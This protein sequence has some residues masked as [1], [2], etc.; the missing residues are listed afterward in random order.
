MNYANQHPHVCSLLVVV[1]CFCA[2]NNNSKFLEQNFKIFCS[3]HDLYLFYFS[4][5]VF[6][7]FS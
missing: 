3:T 1:G 5:S 6:L 4:M 2:E 7:F